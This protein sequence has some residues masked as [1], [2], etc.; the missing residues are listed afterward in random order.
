MNFDQAILALT[1][2]GLLFVGCNLI[3]NGIITYRNGK[4]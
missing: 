1:S 2:I 3:Y 4:C